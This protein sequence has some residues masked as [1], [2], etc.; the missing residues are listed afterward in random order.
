M[1]SFEWKAILASA[2]VFV[3][4]IDPDRGLTQSNSAEVDNPSWVSIIYEPPENS[5]FQDLYDLLR[6]RHALESIQEILSPLPLTR[7]ADD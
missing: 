6:E 5:A 7:S 1:Y 4:V 3:A 2:L